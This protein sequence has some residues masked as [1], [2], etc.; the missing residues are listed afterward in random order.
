MK[1]LTLSVMI[2]A[3]CAAVPAHADEAELRAKVDQLSAQLDALKAEI[4]AM[5]SQT[6]AIATQQETIVRAAPTAS[7]GT[8]EK[9]ASAIEPLTIWGYGEINYNRP[10]HDSSETRM[11]LRRAV[12]GFGYRFNENT[13]FMSEYEVEHAVASADDTG[14][15][16][17]EQFYIDHKLADSVN[18]K[19]GL[20]LIPM[21]LLNESHEPTHYY[22]VERNFVE[23]AI[24]P[25][26]WREGGAAIYGGTES[27]IAWDVGLTTGFDLGK[28]DPASDEGKESPLGSVH[29]ELQNAKA[30]DLSTYVALNYRG[31]PGWVAGGS[32]FTGKVSQG[33]QDIR[34][35]SNAR[36]TLWDAHTRWTPGDF[37]L[38]AVYAKG[39]ISDTTD[40][41]ATFVGNDTLIPK[42]FWGWY[43]QAA[44][45]VALPST[46]S[47]SPFVRY[48]RFNTGASYSDI[49]A[50]LTPDTLATEAVW[51]YG[52]NFNLNPNV[53]FKV[54]YQRFKEDT[55]RNRF[56]LGL[57]LA[58]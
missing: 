13:R 26:T 10:K 54:D 52:F 4:K 48:E 35:A 6:E 8:A 53:V 58:F 46:Y 42:E 41:N 17:V 40:L 33:N 57:G 9:I 14:E 3:A 37:D 19:A 34:V 50:G 38:S 44:Y 28:W 47:I 11:D 21:G 18:L 51:T 22:G 55:D 20:F 45:K 2:A 12:F 24:I 32:V 39:T 49:G 31:V 27:G 7:N 5:H 36:V 1:R 29:Q 56:D 43:T 23:T 25:S 30:R 15:V 16:E